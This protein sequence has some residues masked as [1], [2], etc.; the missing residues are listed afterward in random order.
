MGVDIKY[1]C[2]GSYAY[3]K[4]SEIIIYD[5]I[6]QVFKILSELLELG[7]PFVFLL[8]GRQITEFPTFKTGYFII[9]WMRKH[10]SKIPNILLG[11]AIILKNKTI[12]SILK[13][14]F[15]QQKPI[16]PN[17]ITDDLKEGKKFVNIIYEKNIYTKQEC[18]NRE[19]RIML[20]CRKERNIDEKIF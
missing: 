8:D 17:I 4:L 6:E 18:S 15:T 10:Y 2:N 7:K 13:W 20:E 19:E 1:Y 9:S 14:V 11:S 5:D 16:S 12:I 3:F